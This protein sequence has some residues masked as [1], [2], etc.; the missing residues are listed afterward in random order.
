[1]KEV[2][3]PATPHPPA[4]NWSAVATAGNYAA[5]LKEK[6]LNQRKEQLPQEQPWGSDYLCPWAMG[7]V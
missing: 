6:I 3:K 5:Q 1:M 2:C 4:G 7:G